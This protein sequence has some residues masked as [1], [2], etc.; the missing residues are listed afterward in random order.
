[1]PIGRT[2]LRARPSRACLLGPVGAS[3][4]QRA[5]QGVTK[6]RDLFVAELAGAVG[7]LGDGAGAVDQDAADGLATEPGQAVGVAR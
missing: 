3:G 7:K 5:G 6:Q 4:R 2:E 1:M